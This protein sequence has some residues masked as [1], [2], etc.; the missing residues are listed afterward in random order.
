[1]PIALV[2]QPY[3]NS[4]ALTVMSMHGEE[5]LDK[6]EPIMLFWQRGGSGWWGQHYD[7]LLK[8]RTTTVRD[9]FFDDRPRFSE[10]LDTVDT[11]I[12]F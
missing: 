9:W 8:S 4:T 6:H 12:D 1:M 2:E 11:C 7:L 5:Y 10:C 3:N